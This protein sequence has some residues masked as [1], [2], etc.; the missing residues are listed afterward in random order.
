M[1]PSS[2]FDATIAVPFI[3]FTLIWGS[4]WIVIR[5]Q[6]G[7]VP[8]QWSVTYRFALAGVAM[9]AV[10]K[11]KGHDLALDR[12]GMIAAAVIGVMQF[13]VNFNAVYLA[14]RYVTSGLVATVFALLLIPNSLLAWGFLGQKP[15]KRFF[16]AALVATAGIGLLF[17]HEVRANPARGE[18]IAIGLGLTLIGLLGASVANV[19]QAGREA[20]RHPLFA[21]LA[22]AMLFGALVDAAIAFA[23]AGPPIFDPR[24][25]YW[26]GLAWLSLAATVLCFSL[27]IPVVRKIGPG[28][29]AYSS[30]IVPIIAMALSTMFE[31]YVWAPIAV[32]GAVLALGGMLLALAGRQ[33]PLLVAAPDA[34]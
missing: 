30:V 33:R 2:R 15:S 23:V 9:V 14:E 4:T 7:V 17:V 26:L 8:A 12:G 13:C 11:W 10:A 19:Y 20:R 21:L 27:Y 5:D 31:G 16:C 6:L 3:I 34:G 28:K 24:P 22:W 29:A 1:S 32:A 18:D 25:A